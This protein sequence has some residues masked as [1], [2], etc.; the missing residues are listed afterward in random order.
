MAV[1]GAKYPDDA[2]IWTVARRPTWGSV[3]PQGYA[4]PGLKSR[5]WRDFQAAFTQAFVTP[6]RSVA[7]GDS[8]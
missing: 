5:H 6:G 7:E 2:S 3:G 8:V 1:Y 4:R